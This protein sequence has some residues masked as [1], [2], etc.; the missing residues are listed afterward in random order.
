MN[1]NS[2]FI[3]RKI[4][5]FNRFVSFKVICGFMILNNGGNRQNYGEKRRQLSYCYSDSVLKGINVNL[6]FYLFT[7]KSRVQSL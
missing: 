4:Y 7:M 6:T 2:I 1:E 5:Y 3:C